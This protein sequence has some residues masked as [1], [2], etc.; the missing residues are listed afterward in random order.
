MG[1]Y[2]SITLN[3]FTINEWKNT[4]HRWYFRESDRVRKIDDGSGD[5]IFLG[6]RSTAGVIRKRLELDGFTYKQLESEFSEMRS[7]WLAMLEDYYDENQHQSELTVL[8]QHPNIKSWIDLLLDAQ[9]LEFSEPKKLNNDLLEFMHSDDFDEDPSYSAGGYHFPCKTVEAWA[10]AVLSISSDDDI[11]ELDM[12]ELVNAGWADDFHDIA[13]IQAGKTSF[14]NNFSS[15]IDELV[16]LPANFPEYHLMQRLAFSGVFSALEAYLSDTMKKQVMT[17]PAV[18]R[19][20]VESHDKFAG[21]KKFAFSE[22]FTKLDELDKLI[23]DEL[24]FISFHNMNTIPE[25]F[26]KVLFVEF[27][28]NCIATLCEAVSKRHDI[29]HRNGKNT[30]GKVILITKDDVIALVELTRIVVSEI[31]R[32]ILDLQRDVDD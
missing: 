18:K 7:E 22:I 6:Y 14:H 29:V 2:A 8:R 19:R 10:V 11:V 26:K 24:D 25:L 1:T 16:I 20:F 12:T 9:K 3:G 17:R 15:F 30:T 28:S 4:W 13:E 27:P 32:Q 31:D 21:M 5:Y 23:V